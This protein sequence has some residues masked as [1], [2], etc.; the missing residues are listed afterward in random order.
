[1]PA[2]AP[3]RFANKTDRATGA[4]AIQ[5]ALLQIARARSEKFAGEFLGRG[6]ITIAQKRQRSPKVPTIASKKQ[7]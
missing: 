1:L 5:G 2:S 6:Q 4:Q 7:R 3:E